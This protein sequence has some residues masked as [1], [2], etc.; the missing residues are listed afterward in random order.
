VRQDVPPFANRLDELFAAEAR[1]VQPCEEVARWPQT[2]L[3]AGQFGRTSVQFA[4]PI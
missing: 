4:R 2:R 1:E 3:T